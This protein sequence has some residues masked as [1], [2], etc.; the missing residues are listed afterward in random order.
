MRWGPNSETSRRTRI[1][2]SAALAGRAGDALVAVAPDEELVAT[3]RDAGG[4]GKPLYGQATVCWAATEDEARR[5]MHEIWP[6]AGVPG[7]LSQELPLP[8]HFEQAAEPGSEDEVAEVI[9]CGP[10]PE[11]HL[12]QIR[13]FADAGFDHVYVHQIG[14]DQDGFF[15]FYERE[16][17]PRSPT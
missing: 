17:L 14:P 10:D 3:F 1:G 9:V 8:R 6:N 15:E 16:I 11:P 5:T 2:G 4:E 7:D 12:A 13:E